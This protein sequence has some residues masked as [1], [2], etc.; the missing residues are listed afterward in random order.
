V[1]GYFT[2][3]FPKKPEIAV[4][5]DYEVGVGN[6]N[7]ASVTLPNIGDGVYDLIL[8]DE[9][10]SPFDTGIDIDVAVLDTFDFTTGLLPEIGVEGVSKFSIRGI[11]VAA[12]LDPTDPTEFVTGLTFVGDGEFTG[13]MTPITQTVIVGGDLAVPE[14]GA[15]T[16]FVVSLAG[17]GF[18]RR[19]K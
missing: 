15:L 7:F 19:R 14:P 8:F 9:F 12:G 10:D 18:L 17:L 6:A 2:L 3:W 11:E 4:G 1:Q 5:Y 13:T 16:L